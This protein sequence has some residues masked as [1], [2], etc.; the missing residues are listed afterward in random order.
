MT[1]QDFCP[2]GGLFLFVM[3]V[4][5]VMYYGVPVVIWANKKWRTRK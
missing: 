3:V 1:V 2:V 5:V 4:I